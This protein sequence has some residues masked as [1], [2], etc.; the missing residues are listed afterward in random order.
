M[1][2][3]N[4]QLNSNQSGLASIFVTMVIMTV[5][6]L[7]V[8]GLVQLA[9]REQSSALDKQLA[10][11]AFYAAESG[12]N[13]V[14]DVLVQQSYNLPAKS[15]C[16]QDTLPA[17]ATT[18]GIYKMAIQDGAPGTNV[19]ITCLLVNPTPSS[20]NYN[21][22]T[23]GQYVVSKLVPSGGGNIDS[24]NI[25]W[26]AAQVP[27]SPT[28]SCFGST[29]SPIFTPTISSSC[30]AGVLRLD[31]VGS[32]LTSPGMT[33]YL[34]PNSTAVGSPEATANLTLPGS[35]GNIYSASCNTTVTT[36]L[37]YDCNVM[38]S[39]NPDSAYYL[40]TSFI[41]EDGDANISAYSSGVLQNLTGDQ[42]EV[43]STGQVANVVKRV[44][45]YIS[46]T[47]T[48]GVGGQTSAPTPPPL[49]AL[50][51]N[52]SICKDFTYDGSTSID[53]TCPSYP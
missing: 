11:A 45:E 1:K 47:N 32:D 39:V 16:P 34:Y 6:M 26:Q 14:K 25:S 9:N 49:N 4:K 15:T 8:L 10:T 21:N 20:L 46:L 29:P 28:F 44:K 18:S 7:I 38:L 12:V 31:L 52:N 13:E 24:V 3:I 22:V 53:G 50:N 19:H 51:S 23:T 33:I 43:D 36:T 17:H 40:R 42:V 35:N 27:S 2:N 30:G 5:I 37:P 48:Q 41:Y